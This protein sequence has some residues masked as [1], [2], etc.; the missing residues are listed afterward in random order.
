MDIKNQ[1]INGPGYAIAP[2]DDLKCF[3]KL[4]EVITQ[5][6]QSNKSRIDIEKLRIKMMTMS[7]SEINNIMVGLLSFNQASEIMLRSCRNIVKKLSG[8]EVF[9]SEKS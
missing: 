7:K 5:K 9:F 4:R 6:L 3:E 8:E 1:I 2:I